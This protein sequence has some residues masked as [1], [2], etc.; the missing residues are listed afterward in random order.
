[1]EE[2]ECIRAKEREFGSNKREVMWGG[3][4]GRDGFGR[5]RLEA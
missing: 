4:E 2:S 1:M 5:G 3:D